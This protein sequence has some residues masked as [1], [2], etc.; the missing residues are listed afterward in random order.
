MSFFLNEVGA[1]ATSPDLPG[2]VAADLA[3]PQLFFERDAARH[4]ISKKDAARHSIFNAP[5]LRNVVQA[6]LGYR[7][8][9]HHQRRLGVV[10]LPRRVGPAD[11]R[12]DHQDRRVAA[13]LTRCSSPP[14][15][16]LAPLLAI[17]DVLPPR[18][19]ALETLHPLPPAV[20]H[21]GCRRR[22]RRR[23]LPLASPLHAKC[24]SQ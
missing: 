13:T 17:L 21:V 1:G 7:H 16:S 5:L 23:A 8:R 6:L 14:S 18:N 20:E 19:L 3:R 24:R 12:R 22:S 15:F 11:H 2:T 10:R 9:P 4:S